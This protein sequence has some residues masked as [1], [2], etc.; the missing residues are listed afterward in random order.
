MEF[1]ANKLVKK[2]C[3]WISKKLEKS[4]VWWGDDFDELGNWKV[5]F[6][7]NLG[8]GMTTMAEVQAISTSLNLCRSQGL[9]N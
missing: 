7:K 8:F 5:G 4:C 6:Q 3:E 1:P 2:G 9:C